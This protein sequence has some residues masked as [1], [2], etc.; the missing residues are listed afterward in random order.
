MQIDPINTAG[1]DSKRQHRL[2]LRRLSAADFLGKMFSYIVPKVTLLLH[3]V[4]ALYQVG[5]ERDCGCNGQTPP[6][7]VELV[8]RRD[9]HVLAWFCWKK[10]QKRDHSKKLRE[11]QKQD[12]IDA[13]AFRKATQEKE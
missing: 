7:F 1:D 9:N 6:A 3:A 12:D 2:S 11:L 8:A 4:G 10:Q 5:W 13:A